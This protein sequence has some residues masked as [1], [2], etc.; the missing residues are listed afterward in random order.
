[1][2]EAP[3]LSSGSAFWTVKYTPLAFVLNVLPKCSGVTAGV[4][5]V[6]TI[7][8]FAKRISIVPLFFRDLFVEPIEIFQFGHVAPHGYDIISERL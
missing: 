1:M 3:S 6:S 5:T 4:S 7:P 2:I 8:V